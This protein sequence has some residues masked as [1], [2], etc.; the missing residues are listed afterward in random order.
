MGLDDLGNYRA[1]VRI[2]GR[3]VATRQF[4]RTPAVRFRAIEA[5]LRNR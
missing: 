2:L 4:I 1:I 5:V 3:N